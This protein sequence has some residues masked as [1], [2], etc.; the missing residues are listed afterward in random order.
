MRWLVTVAS[1]FDPDTLREKL[2]AAGCERIALEDA[3][4]LGD[5]E[6]VIPVEG[7]ESLPERVASLK[8]VLAIYPDSEMRYSD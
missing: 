1:Q 6:V 8:Q 7:P 5:D 3:V 2:A 4:P